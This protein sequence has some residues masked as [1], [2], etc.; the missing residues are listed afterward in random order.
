M[1][2]ILLFNLALL[3]GSGAFAQYKND[4]L[5][6]LPETPAIKLKKETDLST[7]NN[8]RFERKKTRANKVVYNHGAFVAAS[9]GIA[10]NDWYSF[11]SS[12]GGTNP[13]GRMVYNYL[14]PDS[15]MRYG[16]SSSSGITFLSVGQVLDPTAKVFKDNIANPDVVIGMSNSYVVD[17]L[18][19][20]CVYDKSP[21]AAN[22]AVNDT[23]ILSFIIEDNNNLP[24]SG[25]TSGNVVTNFGA[26][27]V[28]FLSQAFDSLSSKPPVQFAMAG[29]TPA[30]VIKKVL[31]AAADVDTIGG[32]WNYFGF[33]P[34]LTVPAGKAVSVS[35]SYKPGNTWV[36]G[37]DSI[38][39]FNQFLFVSHEE[40]VGGFFSYTKWDFNSSNVVTKSSNVVPNVQGWG[41]NYLPALAYTAPYAYEFH[42]L[43]WVI[44]CTTCGAAGVEDAKADFNLSVTPN[45][46]EGLVKVSLNAVENYN[47]MTFTVTN[48]VGQTLKSFDM[49]S[50]AANQPKSFQF[51]LSSLPKGLYLYTL[52]A[53]GKKVSDKLMVK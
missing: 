35:V 28:T 10:A 33:K 25:W 42:D 24:V 40:T 7:F 9:Q 34:N 50:A 44:T 22:A 12:F 15:T 43:D 32:G 23:L 29:G 49:G 36:A 2:K 41:G 38:A 8:T 4:Q 45:P 5:L 19:M 30:L 18:Y 20:F 52:T 31:D 46:T 26:D 51:D 39:D 14:W 3:L 48:M 6:Q 13:N 21:I 16:A 47:N 17:S 11:Q 37:V 1:K 27:T 53:D